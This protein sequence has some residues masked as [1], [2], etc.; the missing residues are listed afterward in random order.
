MSIRQSVFLSFSE[1][2]SGDRICYAWLEFYSKDSIAVEDRMFLRMQA[3][4]FAQ[5]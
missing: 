3:F 5:T 2:R 4:I 1:D